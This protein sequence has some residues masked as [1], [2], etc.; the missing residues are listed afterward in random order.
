[1]WIQTVAAA[2]RTAVES[3]KRG[4]PIGAGQ[5]ATMRDACYICSVGRHCCSLGIRAYRKVN[6]NI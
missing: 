6:K 2:E 5:E 3:D 4:R 1:M